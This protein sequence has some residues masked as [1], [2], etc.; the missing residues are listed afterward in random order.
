M[1]KVSDNAVDVDADGRRPDVFVADYSGT[2]GFAASE[3]AVTHTVEVIA[4]AGA[5]LH[6]RRGRRS[7]PRCHRIRDRAGSDVHL[8]RQQRR[9]LRRRHRRHPDAQLA[10][11]EALGITNGGGAA[12]P[13]T[14]QV[15]RC[16]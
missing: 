4:D 3:D 5:V 9:H 2:V 10:V 14:V 7:D 15:T 11:L 13:I 6:H 8:G 1:P 12:T 16:C